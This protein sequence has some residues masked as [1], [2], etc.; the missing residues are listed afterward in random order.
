MELIHGLP[1]YVYYYGFTK[2]QIKNLADMPYKKALLE[3][4]KSAKGILARL[5]DVPFMDQDT[6]RINAVAK[7]IKFN[8]QLLEELL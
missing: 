5:L 4:I 7:A 8:E 3:K 1:K 6:S 2:E